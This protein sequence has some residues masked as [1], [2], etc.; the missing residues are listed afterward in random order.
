MCIDRIIKP[1][2]NCALATGIKRILALKWLMKSS[3]YESS[4]QKT[5]KVQTNFCRE[6]NKLQRA[7]MNCCNTRTHIAVCP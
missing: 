1:F 5:F 6:K 2:Q 7:A 4:T 3:D